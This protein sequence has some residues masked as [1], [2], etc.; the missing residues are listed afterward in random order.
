MG[1]RYRCKTD[2]TLN[3]RGRVFRRRQKYPIITWRAH[4]KINRWWSVSAIGGSPR[5][6]PQ[7]F[8]KYLNHQVLSLSWRQVGRT[9]ENYEEPFISHPRFSHPDQMRS[10]MKSDV[11]ALVPT[12][13]IPEN[14]DG[15]RIYVSNDVSIYFVNSAV[16]LFW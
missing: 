16:H 2:D 14:G 12:L 13:S 4:N 15:R 8:L 6:V 5:R 7:T 1:L 10:F 9:R 11:S 3:I